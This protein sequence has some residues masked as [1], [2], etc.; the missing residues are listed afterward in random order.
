MSYIKFLPPPKGCEATTDCDG[1]VGTQEG[2]RPG[3][4]RAVIVQCSHQ[5]T[6]C[7]AL[8]FQLKRDSS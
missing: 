2:W 6:W 4:R 8:P 3:G 7:C 1:V 5:A